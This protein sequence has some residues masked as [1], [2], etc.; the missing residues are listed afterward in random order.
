MILIFAIATIAGAV[1]FAACKHAQGNDSRTSSAQPEWTGHMTVP[2]PMREVQISVREYLQVRGFRRCGKQGKL[3]LYRRGNR[4]I[5][6]LPCKRNVPWRDVPIM[7]A[8]GYEKQKGV[9]HVGMRISGWRATKFDES[10]E[11]FFDECAEEEFD[12]V[13]E[14]L[15]RG[16]KP[17]RE[18]PPPPPPPPCDTTHDDDL[19]LLGLTRGFSPDQLQAAYRAACR[20]FHPD[21]LV[22]VPEDVVKLAQE[23]FVKVQTAYERLR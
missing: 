14:F 16:I 13:L 8:V 10:V 1:T 11:P 3:F 4:G 12:G 20:K 15:N 7:L 2:R 22:G 9:I 5:R 6:R 18:T 23:H 17:P 21:R 19:K